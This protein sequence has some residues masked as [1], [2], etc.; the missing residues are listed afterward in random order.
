MDK[1]LRPLRHITRKPL[2]EDTHM[3]LQQNQH[4]NRQKII[5]DLGFLL[6]RHWLDQRT[7]HNT[8]QAGT[9]TL[10]RRRPDDELSF[11]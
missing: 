5:Q 11:D 10:L 7:P 1:T 8:D 6:A 9:R 3:K 2:T 4:E